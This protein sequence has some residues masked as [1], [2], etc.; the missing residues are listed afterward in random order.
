MAWHSHPSAGKAEGGGVV[1]FIVVIIINIIITGIINY[2]AKFVLK[3]EKRRLTDINLDN[4]HR[5]VNKGRE[6]V[7]GDRCDDIPR[8]PLLDLLI[9]RKTYFLYGCSA[10]VP[11]SIS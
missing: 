9:F 2:S 8:S 3:E 11:T 10:Q 1:D 6:V 4:D 5:R 7:E